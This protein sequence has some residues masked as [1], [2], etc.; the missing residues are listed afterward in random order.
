MRKM[1]GTANKWIFVM[2]YGCIQ[3]PNRGAYQRNYM[4]NIRFF[5]VDGG[6]VAWVY[7]LAMNN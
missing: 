4:R 5:G 7:H 6:M 2:S 1:R 3:R